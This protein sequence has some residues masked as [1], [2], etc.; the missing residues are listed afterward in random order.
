MKLE[1]IRLQ[2]FLAAQG[3]GSRRAIEQ[4]IIEGR[5]KVNGKVAVLGEKILGNE[6]IYF[7]GKLLRFNPQKE[8]KRQVLIYNKRVGEICARKDPENRPAVYQNLPKIQAGRWVMVGRLD[9]NSS[10]LLLFTND[11]EL[12]NKLMHPSSR[13]EREYWVRVGGTIAEETLEQLKQ[14]VKLEEGIMKFNE[15]IP[16]KVAKE[17]DSYNKFYSVIIKEGKKREVRRLFE[18]VGCMVSRLKRVRYGTVILPRY[19]KEGKT[20]FLDENEIKKLVKLI[21]NEKWAMSNEFI[22]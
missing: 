13:I 16:L 20:Q 11:G 7:D 3:L 10:G 9:L 4:M 12:A 8:I 2:K 14:G 17:E 22:I 21:R 6:K 1:Q 18:A 15:I 19:L 5:I